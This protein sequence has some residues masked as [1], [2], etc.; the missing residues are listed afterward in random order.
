MD[1][2]KN[3]KS[4]RKPVI[5]PSFN[6]EINL[7]RAASD[8]FASPDIDGH[9]AAFC[10]GTEKFRCLVRACNCLIIQL[11]YHVSIAQTHLRKKASSWNVADDKSGRLIVLRKR[12]YG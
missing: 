12:R 11:R 3:F 4:E 8:A 10:Q 7:A 6:V 2:A 5:L 9:L 1:S